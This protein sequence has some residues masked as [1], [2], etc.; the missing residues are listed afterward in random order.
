MLK[1]G[2]N[3]GTDKHMNICLKI[4]RHS[5]L[6][7]LANRGQDF[8][9]FP[10]NCLAPWWALVS[11]CCTST[12]FRPSRSTRHLPVLFPQAF[13]PFVKPTTKTLSSSLEIA[14]RSLLVTGLSGKFFSWRNF[15][16]FF[17]GVS[18]GQFRLLDKLLTYKGFFVVS[19]TVL[20]ETISPL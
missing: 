2:L 9:L 20:T 13:F 4:L 18:P 5:T 19:P 1:I 15:L 6:F 10:C 11:N 12:P 17:T 3:Q 16:T 14:A 8:A 7:L